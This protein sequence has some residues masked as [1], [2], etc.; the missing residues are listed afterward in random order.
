VLPI[1]A[2]GLDARPAIERFICAGDRVQIDALVSLTGFSLVGGPAFNDARAAE[3]I[4]A[5][6]DVPYVAAQPLE[7]QSTE[8]WRTSP[9]GLS[10][11]EATLMVAIPELDGATNPMVFAGRSGKALEPDMSAIP[12]RVSLL[13]RRVARLVELRKTKP[14]E[15]RLA[16]VL[17]N[18]PPNSGAVGTAASLSV[19][20]SLHKTLQALK[21]DGYSVEVPATVDALRTAICVGNSEQYGTDANVCA[22]VDTD[23]YVRAELHLEE[24]EAQWGPAPGTIQSNGRGL[25]VLGARFGNVLVSL[26][27]ALGYEGDPMRLLFEKG[28]APTHAFSASYRYL[29]ETFGAHAALHFGTHGALEFMPGKQAGMSEACWPERLIGDVPHFYL[30]AANNPSEGAIAKR[31]SAAT[32]VS[33]LTPPIVEA[34]LYRGLAALKADLDVLRAAPAD[35][36]APRLVAHIQAQAVALELVPSSLSP[37]AVDD[38]ALAS[39]ST[40][41]A[42]LERTLIPS[43][44]HV[45]G[46]GH[47]RAERTET[48]KA[49][50]KGSP[51]AALGEPGLAAILDGATAKAALDAAGVAGDD[52]LIAS[53]T[54]LI[55]T[56]RRLRDNEELPALI[57]ALGGGFVRPGP[58]GDVLRTPQVLPTGRNIHGFDPFAIPSR[59][60]LHDGAEQAARVLARHVADGKALPRSVALVLWGTDT[61]KTGGGP[62]GQA[63]A[64]LGARPRFDSYGRLAGAE[65]VPLAE[66]GRPRIDVLMTVSGIFRDLLPLQ[67]R[68]LAEA[69]LLAA[70]ADEPLEQNFVRSHTLAHQQHHGCDLETAALRV[71]SN[72]EGAYGANVNQLVDGGTWEDA[73]ELAEAYVRRKSFAY[74]RQGKPVA[75]D[76]LF[77]SVLRNVELTYQ[78]VDSVETGLTSLDQYVDALGGLAR[79]IAKERGAMPEVYVSDQTQGEARVRTLSEQVAVETRTRS[80][81]PRWASA[82]LEHGAEGVRHIEMQV[83]TTMG[84]SA[85]TEQV[86]AWVY[87]DLTATYVLDDE[88]RRRL[89]ELNPRSTLRMA[90]RLIEASERRYWEPDAETLAALHRATDEIEDALEGISPAHAA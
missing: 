44:L 66:L 24:I 56:N 41:I 70:S 48:L 36:A 18:Y 62:I 53:V 16:I 17:F 4:L 90:R 86:G 67:T 8:S 59:F 2:A 11:I 71:F 9:T 75:H 39:L 30:Y 23:T 34:G 13:A 42:E 46:R 31:R 22:V 50:M 5:R 77:R 63:L 51:A 28:F 3:E 7:L 10:G 19:F 76:A 84:W 87:R 68:L 79:S 25:L 45:L 14:A 60:A 58:G 32:L 37:W 38:P 57:H 89:V 26:Q 81:N 80:L 61:L 20:A 74:G 78:N 55:V 83:T 72:A 69:A 33:Y 49:L 54:E 64:L 52:D 82:M 47:D 1:F 21:D 29:R 65:L 40:A 85:T 15:R 35:D 43:G 27:P 6:L 12:D 73:N 88:M